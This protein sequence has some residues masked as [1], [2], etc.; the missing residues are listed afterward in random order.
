MGQQADIR[1]WQPS[2]HSKEIREADKRCTDEGRSE[3]ESDSWFDVFRP[4]KALYAPSIPNVLRSYWLYQ[5]EAL[6]IA[7]PQSFRL[8]FQPR[9]WKMLNRLLRPQ[10]LRNLASVAQS[11]CSRE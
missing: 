10:C 3:L 2:V 8:L 7:S 4:L 5:P 1:R 11:P 6:A 9:R